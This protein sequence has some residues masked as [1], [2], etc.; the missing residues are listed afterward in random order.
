MKPRRLDSETIVSRSATAGATSFGSAVGRGVV[1]HGGLRWA[2]AVAGPVA[3]W[4]GPAM[5]AEARPAQRRRAGQ[6][7]A[8][9]RT[10]DRALPPMTA[11]IVVVVEARAEER[12]GQL[13][14]ARSRRTARAPRH[15]S[16]S[17]A[18]RGRRRRRRPRSAIDRAIAAASSP[19]HA[20]G[21]KP[22]PTTPPVAAIPR[23]VLVGQVAGVVGARRGRRC[24]RRRPAG[25]PSARTSSIVAAEAWAT[26]T[27]I[28]RASIRATISRPAPVRPPFS[29][30]CADPPNALSKKWR[31]RHHPEP[32]GDDDARRSPGRRRARGRP[33]SRAAPAVSAGR[34]A[35]AAR[36]RPSRSA[37]R[38]DEP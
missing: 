7:Q 37:A 32:G 13:D 26:S 25:S 35:R 34:P 38:P 1:G 31:R 33:R 27:S 8:S 9:R 36:D 12:V 28:R 22:I 14:H 21:Q 18:R 24:A 6:R 11:P 23:S 20:V 2:P 16:P 5:L 17:R 19:P 30:P 3:G 10:P 4:A 15:R 29:T